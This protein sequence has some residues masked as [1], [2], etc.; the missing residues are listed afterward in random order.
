MTIQVYIATEDVPSEQVAQKLIEAANMQVAYRFRSNGRT[1]LEK[2]FGKYINLAKREAVLL[3]A[4]FDRS[5]P[6]TPCPSRL[7]EEWLGGKE[8][9]VKLLARVAV[10]EIESWLLADEEAF[11]RFLGG[12]VRIPANCDEIDDPKLFILNAARKKKRLGREGFFRIDP[13]GLRP[14]VEYNAMLSEWIASEWSPERAS[15]KS[16]SL[17]RAIERLDDLKKLYAEHA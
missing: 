3:I 10:H 1:Y 11:R 5:T 7:I 15:K 4:D 12:S 13:G 8:K 9:P 6:K 17:K 16:P 2:N 14:G